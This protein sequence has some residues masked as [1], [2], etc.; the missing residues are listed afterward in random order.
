MHVALLRGK[1]PQR[2]ASGPRRRT[3]VSLPA[4][5][6]AVTLRFRFGPAAGR[7]AVRNRLVQWYFAGMGFATLRHVGT[8]DHLHVA[9]R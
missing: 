9:I 2:A 3:T 5:P 7:S 4:F 8:A 6:D 1:A